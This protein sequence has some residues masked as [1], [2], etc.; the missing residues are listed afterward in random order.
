M[1]IDT[2]QLKSTGMGFFRTLLDFSFSEFVTPKIIKF[3]YVVHLIICVLGALVG[4]VMILIDAAATN[5]ATTVLIA[6]LVII[7]GVPFG[8]LFYALVMRVFLEL[9]VVIFNINKSAKS[10]AERFQ[11]AELSVGSDYVAAPG[12][13]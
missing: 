8:L 7:V 3:L 1:N 10:I 2:N 9:I 12:E 11:S 4:S 6:L 5:E 13:E